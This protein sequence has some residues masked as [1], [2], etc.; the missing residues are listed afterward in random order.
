MKV[1]IMG[2][3]WIL[4]VISVLGMKASFLGGFVILILEIVGV[5]TFGIY[6]ILW[7]SL[8]AIV[9]SFCLFVISF[10]SLMAFFDFKYTT[11]KRR[12]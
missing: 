9:V 8:C 2:F 10:V 12:R 3:F 5:T 1:L 4:S 6:T 7:Y 11:Y